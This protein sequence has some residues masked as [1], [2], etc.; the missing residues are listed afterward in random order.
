[1]IIGVAL[2][3]GWLNRDDNG[4]SADSGV[5]YWLGVAGSS[6]ML[7]SLLYPL[8]KRVR[9]LR[10][11]GTI[12]FWFRAHMTLGIIGSALICWHAN[13]RLGSIN[14][15]VAFVAVLVVAVSGI[16]GRYF[17]SQIHLSLYG[18]R[19]LVRE[20]LSDAEA[21]KD[22]IGAE[23]PVADRAIEDLNAFARRAT[24]TPKS[25]L[26]ELLLLPA[27]SWHG[28]VVRMRLVAEVRQ[29]IRSDGKRL[30]WSRKVRRQRAARVADLV[31]LQV[32]A[33]KKAGAFAFYE[34]VF[35]AWHVLHIP[36]FFL[37]VLATII[38]VF[39]AHFF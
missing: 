14:D 28:T 17:Y 18:R 9:Y 19:A 34:R 7:A 26:A 20:L 10:K 32:S 4:L 2:V 24:A 27:I 21:L 30:G 35:K 15:S 1:M 39:A 13:F 11:L 8:R 38:H 16:V 12:S 36:L 6:L 5:G 22:S 29:V 33:V 37:F 25:V 23:L 31:R 3:I